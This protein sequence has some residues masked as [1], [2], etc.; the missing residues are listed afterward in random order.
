MQLPGTDSLPENSCEFV[1]QLN[2]NLSNLRE[3]SYKFQKQLLEEKLK[4]EP[5][6]DKQ[7]KYQP[8]DYVLY[9]RG[10]GMNNNKLLPKF[11]G[12]YEVI[13]H[14][15]NDVT[16]R[17]LITG[18][19]EPSFQASRLKMWHGTKQEAYNA[20]MLDNDQYVVDEILAYRGDPDQRTSME[21]EVK[22]ADGTILWKTWD[23]DLDTTQAYEVFV[24]A[25]PAL[26]P[27]LYTKEIA[28]KQRIELNRQPI[29]DVGPGDSVY[30]DIRFYSAQ[31][32]ANLGLEEA[33][34]N[35]YVVKYDY[36][37]WGTK[38]HT[39][40]VAE[41]AVFDEQ[42]RVTHDFVQRYGKCKVMLPHM[43]LV[44]KA[45]VLIYPLML[46][47]DRRER[48]LQQYRNDLGMVED[49]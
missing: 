8:G 9:H 26:R 35:M 46:Q 13:K 27:L 21:F 39:K 45:Q 15:R 28:D 7:N 18:A 30:V 12:P 3:T 40:L 23:K 22:F 31:W 10:A 29:T 16:C 48:L 37:R 38:T 25:R 36:V 5:P 19:V 33:E 49:I 14:Y 47:E 34:H 11:R 2:E 20:A 1:R 41:C 24:R 6:E 43:K 4:D 17:N 44:D 32:Y 42:H